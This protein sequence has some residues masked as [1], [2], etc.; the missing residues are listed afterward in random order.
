M[1][2]QSNETM[3]CG[4]LCKGSSGRVVETDQGARVETERGV[5]KSS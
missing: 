3:K 2:L 4:D 1:Y 5:I